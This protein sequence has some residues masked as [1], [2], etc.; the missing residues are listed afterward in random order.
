[1]SLTYHRQ[2]FYTPQDNFILNGNRAFALSDGVFETIKVINGKA[3]HLP[4][5]LERLEKSLKIIF[6]EKPNQWENLPHLIEEL[7][8]KSELSE[9][10]IRLTLYRYSQQRGLAIN[11]HCTTEF[12]LQI[13][14]YT[15]P[16]TEIL[17]A[18]I[19]S[20]KRNASS[21]TSQIKSLAYLDNILA[22]NKAKSKGYD[23]ALF[24]NYD[25][26]AVCFTIGNLLLEMP[27]G[28]YLSPLPSDGCIE[29]ITLRNSPHKINYKHI[30]PK[31]LKDAKNIYRTNSLT[32]LVKVEFYSQ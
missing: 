7:I 21:P 32:G 1:M 29:G 13:F 17:K 10:S 9:A 18:C 11:E 12:L 16:H 22:Q 2:K 5:H 8:Q 24:F 31:M 30:T 19:S 27:W 14:P 20:I 25:G 28:E 23:E 3:C 6:L 15:T 26:Y 4:H